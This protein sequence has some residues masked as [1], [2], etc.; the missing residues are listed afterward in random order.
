MYAVTVTFEIKPDQVEAFMPLMVENAR[1]SL[2]QEPG[3]HQFDICRDGAV[4]FLYELYDDRA[5]FD[6]HLQTAHFL[7]FDA[8]VGPM[9]DSKSIRLF[10]EVIQ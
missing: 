2:E 5:A 3:C 6:A 10:K 9:I 1:A 8:A 4:V 7:G